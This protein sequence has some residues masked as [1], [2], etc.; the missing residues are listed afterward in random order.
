MHTV[1]AVPRHLTQKL[2]ILCL[3]SAQQCYICKFALTNCLF[4]PRRDSNLCFWDI[5]APNRVVLC[6]TLLF[7]YA[8][9]CISLV[10]ITWLCTL[11]DPV[12]MILFYFLSLWYISIMNCKIRWTINVKIIQSRSG[13]NYLWIL[14]NSIYNFWTIFKSRSISEIYSY[15]LLI[16]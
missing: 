9:F 8:T 10:L 15:I 7:V 4:F 13:I 14:I 2:E 16:F 11:K 5:V 6:P 12:S 3:T 1:F